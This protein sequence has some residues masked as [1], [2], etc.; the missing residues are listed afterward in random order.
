MITLLFC[1]LLS[2][3]QEPTTL[4]NPELYRTLVQPTKKQYTITD[5]T[6][7]ILDGKP[8]TIADLEKAKAVITKIVVDND[9][10]VLRLEAKT[11][12]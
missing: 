2:L 6:V 9:N 12:K 11:P 5:D 10:K 3:G 8:A 7:I 1:L 4:R